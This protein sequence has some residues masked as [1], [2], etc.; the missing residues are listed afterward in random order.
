MAGLGL[1][2]RKICA[3]LLTHAH[4]DHCGGAE[5]LRAATGAG[6]F[7]GASDAEVIKAGGPREAFFSIFY[8]PDAN[9]HPTTVDV[10]LEG[11]EMIEFG[12]VPSAHWVLPATRPEASAT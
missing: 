5:H 4:G 11:D 2:W 8:N 9:V 7:A 1:D 6:V 10:E 3:I 12:G